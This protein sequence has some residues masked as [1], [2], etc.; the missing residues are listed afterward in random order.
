MW[1]AA[2]PGVSNTSNGP[3]RSPS[4]TMPTSPQILR[5]PAPRSGSS[6]AA[7]ARRGPRR[8]VLVA[9]ERTPRRHGRSAD[10]S[11]RC[12]PR[13]RVRAAASTTRG[14]GA[15]SGGPGSTTQAG[16]PDQVCVGPAERHR[17]GVRTRARAPRR[18]DRLPR[19]CSRSILAAVASLR[20]DREL[21]RADRDTARRLAA[22]PATAVARRAA[23]E[24]VGAARR[25]TASCWSTPASTSRARSTS[26][27]AR[28]TRPGTRSTT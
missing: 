24:R 28:C 16:A 23:C 13:P 5:H 6:P 7:R 11:A 12:R 14:R 10:G 18:S 9:H 26:C 22:A 1:S 4:R 3:S 25:A 19:A 20:R 2:C 27:S 21:G 8:P 15:A 17:A